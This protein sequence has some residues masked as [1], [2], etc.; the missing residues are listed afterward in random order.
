M[1]YQLVILTI[2]V[3]L[4]AAMFSE[5]NLSSPS[6]ANTVHI[7][8]HTNSGNPA[9]RPKIQTA[10]QL[11]KKAVH[12]TISVDTQWEDPKDTN[13][14]NFPHKGSA[15]A[16][17]VIQPSTMP[18]V[19]T[20]EH[21][22]AGA[23]TEK[24]FKVL[25][26]FSNGTSQEAEVIGY[27][28]IPLDVALLKFKDPNFKPAHIAPLGNSDE[29]SEGE[30]VIGLGHPYGIMNHLTTG[31][32]SRLRVTE[33][34]F[35]YGPGM[36]ASEIHIAPGN[37]GGPFFNMRG[38]LMGINQRINV[39]NLF[40]FGQFPAIPLAMPVNQAIAVLP[41][42]LQGGEIK[43]ADLGYHIENVNNLGQR[44]LRDMGFANRPRNAPMVLGSRT[45]NPLALPKL[46]PFSTLREGDIILMY[47]GKPVKN[48]T[49]IKMQNLMLNP[50]DKVTV[51]ILRNGSKILKEVELRDAKQILGTDNLL[52]LE[53]LWKL[54]LPLPKK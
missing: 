21:C 10:K 24:N 48:C 29:L 32:I 38:E 7:Y 11:Y 1:K 12:Y 40:A 23:Y 16:G 45:A 28:Q 8:S 30:D 25:I 4:A 50:K 36:I 43:T 6:H 34:P 31:K 15:C 18:Y 27:N 35:Y 52:L 17:V 22:F 53:K 39:N 44:E 46:W 3:F 20:A 47:N 19:L 13:N 9:P 14:P 51:L 5:N 37:S 54:T 2:T 26:N 41:K 49:D 33:I 42:L